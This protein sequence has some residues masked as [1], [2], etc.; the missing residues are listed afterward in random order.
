MAGTSPAMTNEEIKTPQPCAK[1]ARVTPENR[2][3]IWAEGSVSWAAR[4]GLVAFSQPLFGNMYAKFN[5]ELLQPSIACHKPPDFSQAWKWVMGMRRIALVAAGLL[6]LSGFAGE[7]AA[8]D[9]PA[10]PYTAPPATP[11]A[12]YNWTGCYVGGHLGGVISEDKHANG[13]SFS[14]AGFV[15][16]G[17]VGCDYQFAFGWVAGV[18]G[19]AVWSSLKDTHA[20]TLRSSTG[21]IIP[22]QFTVSNDF[23]AS[24]TARLG[25]SFADRW[26]VF[27]TGGAAWT[28]E[29]SDD[30]FTTL[31]GTAV[32]PSASAIR[33]G[34]TAGAGLE[35]A[36][37]RNW[38]AKL[39]YDY[40]DFGSHAATLTS[41]NNGAVVN[42]RGL[43]DTVH[44][45]AVGL[46]YHF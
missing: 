25:Y 2:R 3:G 24:A 19:R 31:G 8:A 18:E 14:S 13:V 38:S 20:L 36:F 29:K 9:L 33:T 44:E 5:F 34:W 6:P 21:V 42:V 16:G 40:Y 23:L 10:N 28:E 11:V 7:A 15:G 17:Q 32:D 22:S 41:G 43:T 30:A 1:A 35:Y 39:E 26:L 46:N 37:S 27:A 12:A 4:A 45:L